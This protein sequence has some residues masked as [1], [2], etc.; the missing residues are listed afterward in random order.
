MRAV[1]SIVENEQKEI[2]EIK[3]VEVPKIK[4][5]EILIETKAISLNP[6]DFKHA[7]MIQGTKMGTDAGGVVVEVGKEVTEFKV[8]DVVSTWNHG[9]VDGVRGR[10]SEYVIGDKYNTIKILN[11]IQK[12][13]VKPGQNPSG[14]I[15]SFEAAST[16]GLGLGT[17][18][19][20]FNYSLGIEPNPEKNQ[21][22]YILIWSGATATGVLAIQVAKAIYGLKV[23]TT[24]SPKNFE[25]LKSLGAD[26]VFNHYDED[27]AKQISDFG[28]GKIEYALDTVASVETWQKTY[29][30]TIGSNTKAIDNI[31]GKSQKDLNY[32]A[33]RNIKFTFTFLY[34]G[35]GDSFAGFNPTEELI[36][37]YRDFWVNLL[38]KHVDNLRT[39]N[40]LLLEGI[41]KVNEGMNLLRQNKVS[42]T[43]VTITI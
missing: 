31:V 14:P 24:G 42:G 7:A 30:S 40:I 29:D 19:V 33:S 21:N 6:T 8:G 39:A 5:D 32:D 28:E 15:N 27:V 26:A 43:K 10:F 23:I 38:P 1:F 4:A 9:G 17:V 11:P 20:S 13:A 34:L 18:G 16:L 36:E 22:S 41:E 35:L 12:D 3:E 25:L 2:F 37:K